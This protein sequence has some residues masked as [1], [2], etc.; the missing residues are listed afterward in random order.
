MAL[1]D[2][3]YIEVAPGE[4]VETQTQ[5][6]SARYCG[7]QEKHEQHRFMAGGY[8]L[9]CAGECAPQ[10]K[11]E[12][13]E[14]VVRLSYKEVSKIAYLARKQSRTQE[15]RGRLSDVTLLDSLEE[16]MRRVL[17]EITSEK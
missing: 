10:P 8:L 11:Q 3:A 17:S 7:I 4:W 9:A 2:K 14:Y 6:I 16:K 5:P 1:F 13:P 12:E 15:K